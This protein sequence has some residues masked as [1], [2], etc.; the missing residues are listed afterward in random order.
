MPPIGVTGFTLTISVGSDELSRS[1]AARIDE[2]LLD[3][4][5]AGEPDLLIGTH[6]PT[7]VAVVS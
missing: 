7:T 4:R 1:E 5:F 3:E 6:E 2:R